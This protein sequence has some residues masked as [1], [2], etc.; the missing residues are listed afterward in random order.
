MMSVGAIP[1][2][3]CHVTGTAFTALLRVITAPH[4]AVNM[5][6]FIA[7]PSI[8]GFIASHSIRLKSANEREPGKSP[9]FTTES[10]ESGTF[11]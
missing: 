3:V 4:T 5:V 8:R 11:P 9:N 6:V 1:T 10:H 2:C 7:I